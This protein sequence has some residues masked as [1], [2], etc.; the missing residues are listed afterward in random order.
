MTCNLADRS[1]FLTPT[2][3]VGQ[4]IADFVASGNDYQGGFLNFLSAYNDDVRKVLIDNMTRESRERC[5]KEFRKQLDIHPE[6]AGL[7]VDIH[8]SYTGSISN[9]V[10]RGV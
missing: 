2:D 1:K 5:E 6:V 4:A 10:I 3:L 9:I 7:Q 8:Y